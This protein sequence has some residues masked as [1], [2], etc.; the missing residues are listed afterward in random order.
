MRVR[1]NAVSRKLTKLL[2]LLRFPPFRLRAVANILVRRGAAPSG[3]PRPSAYA[4]NHAA[5][6]I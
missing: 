5:C 1:Q 4:A 6:I 2:L 3:L